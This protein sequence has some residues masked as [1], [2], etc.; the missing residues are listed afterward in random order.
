VLTTGDVYDGERTV[1][2]Q[3]LSLGFSLERHVPADHLPRAIDRFVELGV[4]R[5]LA[6]FY[7]PQGGTAAGITPQPPRPT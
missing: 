2:H 5:H 3:P 1:L 6:P 7:S 4:R